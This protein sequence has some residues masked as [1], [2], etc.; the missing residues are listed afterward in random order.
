MKPT[1][2]MIPQP[3]TWFPGFVR[4]AAHAGA[5]LLLTAC[6]VACG[7]SAEP[8]AAP[9]PALPILQ[10]EALRFPSG[11]PHLDLLKLAPAV[12][13]RTMDVSLPA[14]LVWNEEKTQR[15]TPAFAGRV[16]AIHADVG[17]RVAA[18]ATLLQ[19]ASP[20]FGSAQAD[21]AR[22]RTD[23]QLAQKAEAR[24]KELFELGIVARKD[25]EQAQADV[26]RAQT[27]ATRATARTQLYGANGAAVNQQLA[28]VAHLSGTVVERNVNPG[29]ELRPELSGPG[30]PPLFVVSDPTS[31]WVQIDAREA[32]SALLRPGSAFQLDVGALPGR[33]FSGTVKTVADVIDPTTRTVKIRGQ[34]A[35][36]DRLL[37]AEML[38]TAHIQVQHETGVLVPASAVLLFGA[39]HR[40]FVQ[41]EPGVFAPRE[42]TLGYEGPQEVLV[43]KGLAVGDTVVSENTLLL[44]RQLRSAREAAG[45]VVSAAAQAESAVKAKP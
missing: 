13:P 21:V 31:L 24:Q 40:V 42:V 8:P 10:G 35:N 2:A 25:L 34:V 28:L 38:A 27:E 36:P 12:A 15:I 19:L 16:Q 14:R 6:L 26:A 20:D 17:Q 30:V 33:L 29:Q 5:G 37:K 39:K 1:I 41:T 4:R 11:H 45:A 9:A 32:E 44:A 3:P 43:T 18:G 22:A 23:L 7:K